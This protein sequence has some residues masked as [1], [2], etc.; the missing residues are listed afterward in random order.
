MLYF[1]IYT[2]S[3]YH[4]KYF[5]FVINYYTQYTVRLLYL[6]I[7]NYIY[8]QIDHIL[9]IFVYVYIIIITEFFYNLML[10]PKPSILYKNHVIQKGVLL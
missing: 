1:L 5:I 8:K 3:F 2:K 6:C 4:T 9:N 7:I 10:E